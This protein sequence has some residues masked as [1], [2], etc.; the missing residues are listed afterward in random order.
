MSATET[1]LDRA[2]ANAARAEENRRAMPQVSA[3][4]DDARQH[5]GLGVSVKY[6]N[7][8]GIER[9]KRSAEGVVAITVIGRGKTG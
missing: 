7:E 8:N 1:A 9:G 2:R 4:V 5:L 6:A 3:W